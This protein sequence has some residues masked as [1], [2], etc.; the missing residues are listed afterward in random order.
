MACGLVIHG[1]REAL[2]IIDMSDPV[3]QFILT[4]GANVMFAL[5]VVL[6]FVLTAVVIWKRLLRR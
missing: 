5:G 6:S 3:K 2:V 1:F 4:A